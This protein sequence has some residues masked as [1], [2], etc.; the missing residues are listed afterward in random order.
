MI[1]P[2]FMSENSLF[3]V[4]ALKSQNHLTVT[5]THSSFKTTIKSVL[6][7]PIFLLSNTIPNPFTFMVPD[8]EREAA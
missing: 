7:N 4:Q 3:K 2:K 1:I 5:P 6:P 8:S